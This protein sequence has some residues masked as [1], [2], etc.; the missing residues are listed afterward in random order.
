MSGQ[1]CRLLRPYMHLALPPKALPSLLRASVSEHTLVSESFFS[2]CGESRSAFRIDCTAA[3]QA[4]STHIRQVFWN[5]SPLTV[6]DIFL[7]PIHPRTGSI[8]SLHDVPACALVC[9]AELTTSLQCLVI[10]NV[11]TMEA[12][13]L[14]PGVRAQAVDL[15]FISSVSQGQEATLVHGCIIL[16]FTTLPNLKHFLATKRTEVKRHQAPSVSAAGPPLYRPGTHMK[17]LRSI[18]VVEYCGRQ[19]PPWNTDEPYDPTLLEMTVL[20]EVC[21]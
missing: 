14:C 15:P 11:L 17:V 7:T 20:R 10:Y 19:G 8:E 18:G 2:S 6:L 3:A 4:C 1:Y 5:G 21:T 16:R 13:Q 12:P 9:G